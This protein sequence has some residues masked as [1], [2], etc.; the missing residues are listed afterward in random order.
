MKYWLLK[1]EPNTWS[2][3]QQVKRGA[4]GE[5]WDGVRNHQAA[6]FMKAM[7][8]GDQAFFYH[9]GKDKAVV[10]IVEI[11]KEHYLDPTD[12]QQR[13]VAVTVKAKETLGKPVTLNQIKEKSAL[14]DML[15]IR[16]SRL[17][18]MPITSK[19][20]KAICAMAK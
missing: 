20:W 13:F 9:S 2:W 11:T 14:S 6:N 15:L 12:E 8:K 3:E 10:G 1:S 5:M 7:K 4:K 19:E 17:S 16:Q 18:V